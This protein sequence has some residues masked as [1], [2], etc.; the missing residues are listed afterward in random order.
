MEIDVQASRTIENL[1]INTVKVV[2]AVEETNDDI[3]KYHNEIYWRFLFLNLVVLWAY[4]SLISAQNY[5]IKF[6]PLDHLDFWGTVAVGSSVFFLHI[7][8]LYFGF[9]KYGFTKRIIPGFIGYII[10]AVLVMSLKNKILLIIA[11]ASVGALGT[12]TESPL[13]G[14]AGLFQTGSFT[15]AA[16]VGSGMAGVL[17]VSAN[18]IIRLIVLLIH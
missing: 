4:Q 17:N 15:Q 3:S 18:T 16:Q 8:Q 1:H 11:F 9:Y 14:I 7:I 6:F 10:I 5:Y 13:F 2:P 12:L